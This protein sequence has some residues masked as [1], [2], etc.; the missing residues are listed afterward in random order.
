MV[1]VSSKYRHE[2]QNSIYYL[3]PGTSEVYMLDFRVKGFQKELLK[4][5]KG[6]HQRVFPKE[7]TSC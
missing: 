1:S 7:F 6:S 5:A 2:N 3:K 4:W